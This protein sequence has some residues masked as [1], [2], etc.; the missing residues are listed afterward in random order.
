TVHACKLTTLYKRLKS[1]AAILNVTQI[2]DL[3]VEN[4]E[5]LNTH[6]LEYEKV[7]KAAM[8]PEEFEKT[9]IGSPFASY[10]IE[11]E[12]F[13]PMTMVSYEQVLDFCKWRSD[14]MS[15]VLGRKVKYRLPT[16]REWRK[17]ATEVFKRNETPIVKQLM[18]NKESR[19]TVFYQNR[20]FAFFSPP[21]GDEVVHLFDNVSE[22][23]ATKGQALGGNNNLFLS[24]S[25]SIR[26]VLNYKEPQFFLGFRCVVEF[27]ED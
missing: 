13:Y 14:Y 6:W 26:R 5:V 3:W 15:K 27:E 23:T 20:L 8:T 22:M 18:A 16:L 19:L 9:N 1:P 10:L 21:Y 12:G 4:T 25:E 7:Q 24:P 2:G 17:I 11:K